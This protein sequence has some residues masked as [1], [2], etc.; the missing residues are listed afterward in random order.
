MVLEPL[1]DE[2]LEDPRH[3]GEKRQHGAVAKVPGR[4]TVLQ[5]EAAERVERLVVIVEPVVEPTDASSAGV[6][7]EGRA[8]DHCAVAPANIA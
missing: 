7:C 2:E 3:V 1:G 6:R 4:T 5:K 8:A